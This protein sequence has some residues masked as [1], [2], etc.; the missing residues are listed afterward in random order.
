[1]I[2]RRLGTRAIA[3]TDLFKSA[4]LGE[5]TSSTEQT[6]ANQT[7]AAGA[8]PVVWYV[9]AGVAAWWFLKG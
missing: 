3:P 2:N 4:A 1:M 6:V 7:G 9:L 8:P 5:T